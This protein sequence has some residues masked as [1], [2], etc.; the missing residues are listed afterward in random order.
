MF[1]GERTGSKALAY[2][3]RTPAEKN[4]GGQAKINN[5]AAAR[6]SRE[7]D[8]G[9]FYRT[10]LSTHLSFITT[11][12]AK[13]VDGFSRFRGDDTAGGSGVAAASK[14]LEG[15]V[16]SVRTVQYLFSDLCWSSVTCCT[17][18]ISSWE[19]S[20]LECQT[21]QTHRME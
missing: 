4:E 13:A 2:Q 15:E 12:N 20:E 9:E 3:Y 21:S 6:S 7:P 14:A 16:A 8:A 1:A 10:A 18:E 11:A 17:R 19:H 5:T